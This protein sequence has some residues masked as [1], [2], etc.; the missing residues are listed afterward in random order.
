[1]RRAPSVRDAGRRPVAHFVLHPREATP[2]FEVRSLEEKREQ[3]VLVGLVPSPAEDESLT[4]LSLLAR[5]AGA[6]VSHTLLQRRD[7][8]SPGTF[9]SKGKLGQLRDLTRN[10]GVDLIIF[11]DDLSPAQVKNLEDTLERKVLD[12]SEL[13]LAIFAEHARTREARLQVELAQLEYLLPRLTRMWGHLSRQQG[14]I[15]T[16]GPGE[17]QLEVDRRRVREKIAFLKRKLRDVDR[18][19]QVQRARRQG[20]HRTALVGYTNAGKSTLMNALTGAHVLTEDKLF[21]TLDATTRRYRYPDGRVTLFTD[22]VGFIRKLP[23]HL[24]ASFRSTLKEV[25]EADLLL[26]VVDASSAAAPRQIEA[27]NRVLEE[28]GVTGKPTLIVLNKTDAAGLDRVI[29]L[30]ARYSGAVPCSALKTEGLDAV[31]EAVRSRIVPGNGRP[32]D[33]GLPVS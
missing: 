3:A 24:V 9:L 20:T 5:T 18:E 19:R 31:R 7:A 21:A 17:T 10:G 25:V 23:H 16:R 14:G 6:D 11:D 13:I 22:T 26:H 28:L 8:I 32:A 2:I 4:E 15:G 12:R 29:E 33:G 30:T 1:M 27:V